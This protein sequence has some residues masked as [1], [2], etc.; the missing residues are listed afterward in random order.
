MGVASVW[1]HLA[2]GGR[3]AGVV[4]QTHVELIT[5]ERV[6]VLREMQ[7]APVEQPRDGSA[8]LEELRRGGDG[9]EGRARSQRVTHEHIGAQAGRASNVVG[10]AHL[11]RR[12]KAD[13]NVVKWRSADG[14][15]GGCRGQ[16]GIESAQSRRE[17]I[18]PRWLRR[19][20]SQP[21]RA[22]W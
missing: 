18:S 17:R 10:G 3:I 9:D 1:A 11:R 12:H 14:P 15:T 2:K 4:R 7:D 13:G 20:R 6:H 22:C 8:L 16:R 5:R 21:R 19:S